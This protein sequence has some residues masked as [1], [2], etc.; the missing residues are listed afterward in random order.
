MAPSK[1]QGKTATQQNPTCVCAHLVIVVVGVV[2]EKH[3]VDGHL[4]SQLV[5]HHKL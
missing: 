5:Q 4:I 2:K 3:H 1:Q